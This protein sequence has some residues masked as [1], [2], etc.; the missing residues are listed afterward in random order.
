MS[1]G[2]RLV[3]VF[4]APGELFEAIRNSARSLANWL[5]PSALVAVLGIVA[6]LV[7]FGDAA[8]VQQALAM[9]D[10]AY[11][12]AVA[13]GKMTP[14]QVEQ[15]R[16]MMQNVGIIMMRVGGSVWMLLAAF[17]APLWWALLGWLIGRWVFRAEAG[18]LKVLEVMGL[19]S[20]IGGVGYIVG[21]FIQMGLGRLGAGPHLATLV[22]PFDPTNRA[23]IALAAANV[24]ALWQ[25]GVTGLGLAT[26]FGRRVAPVLG[27]WFVVW[28]GYK[29]IAV[30]L[31]L[32]Q[33]AL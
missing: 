1:L 3:N 15:V 10:K 25:V 28:A 9:Q 27:V 8:L 6:T 31:R 24:F 16:E 17:V 26:L 7:V 21:M 23:H 11:E 18:F 30:L 12:Q 4:A 19:A 5:V 14:E 32:V 2:S 20:L 33:F 22:D 29:A 13:E